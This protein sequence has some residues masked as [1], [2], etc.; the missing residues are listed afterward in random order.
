VTG[1][2]TGD[3]VVAS[4][5]GAPDAEIV[6]I[7]VL[8]SN[9]AFCCASDVIMA[10]DWIV[11]DRPDVDVVNMSLGTSALYLGDC[12]AAN[13]TT[14]A[15]ATVINTLRADDTLSVVCSMNNGSGTRMAA[16]ACVAN[17]ISV[18]AVWDANVGSQTILGCTDAT[19]A[20]DKVTCFSNSNAKT[21]LFAP[22]APITASGIG[23]GTVSYFGTSQAAPHVAACTAALRQKSPLTA[24]GALE[25]ALESSPVSVT[26]VTNGLS[27][28]RLD[29]EQALG[30]VPTSV[31]S[32]SPP[33][34]ALLGAL[35]LG[36]A[37]AVG[38][39]REGPGGS[40]R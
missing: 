22:G 39:W 32:L 36:I 14:S 38:R 40:G 10:L 25:A 30:Q 37:L 11:T 6:A 18:G 26:D 20:P 21:D 15:F 16:P 35:I 19:T 7:K 12:D 23:G 24:A 4:I 5:G 17:A 29:C 28:P 27:F 33:S 1:I 3:G 34:V 2:V 31:P 9:N 13:A 8:D